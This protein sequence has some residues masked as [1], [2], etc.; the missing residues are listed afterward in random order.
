MDEAVCVMEISLVRHRLLVSGKGKNIP[1]PGAPNPA[2]NFRAVS[3]DTTNSKKSTTE[4]G[5][6]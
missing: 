5:V 6:R 4:T 1:I 3:V 2:L